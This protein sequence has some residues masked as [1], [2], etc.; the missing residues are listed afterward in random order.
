MICSISSSHKQTEPHL[1]IYVSMTLLLF[2]SFGIKLPNINIAT[3]DFVDL[4]TKQK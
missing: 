4:I 1:H 3:D 2:F